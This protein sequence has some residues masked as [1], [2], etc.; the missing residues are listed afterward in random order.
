MIPMGIAYLF[1]NFCGTKYYGQA[2][3]PFLT[4][5]DY[6]SPM[7]G[8]TLVAIGYYTF[9]FFCHIVNRLQFVRDTKG[10]KD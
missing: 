1:V 6:K 3:Y 2:L 10:I 8:F 7:I 5:E 9:D 4:W